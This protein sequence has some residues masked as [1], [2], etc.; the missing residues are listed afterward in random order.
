[1]KDLQL[2]FN[3]FLNVKPALSILI[4]SQIALL[5][6][7]SALVVPSCPAEEVLLLDR[8]ISPCYMFTSKFYHL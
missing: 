4:Q 3:F 6:G 7:T 2:N 1:M 8:L 5:K